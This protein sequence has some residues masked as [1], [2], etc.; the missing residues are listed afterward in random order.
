MLDIDRSYVRSLKRPI[1]ESN[2]VTQR[3]QQMTRPLLEVE[4]VVAPEDNSRPE[5]PE[6]K[7][8]AWRRNSMTLP[9]FFVFFVFFYCDQTD[10]CSQA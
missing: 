4:V 10:S 2:E 8:G 9:T 5:M 3:L 1:L 7:L 6:I